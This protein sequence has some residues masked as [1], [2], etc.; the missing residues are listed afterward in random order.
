MLNLTPQRSDFYKVSYE[1]KDDVLKVVIND[2]EE[3]F[4]FTEMPNG[5]AK[6]DV[7][8]LS[9]NPFVEVKRENG[10]LNITVIR[11]Y[12]LEEKGEFENGY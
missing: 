11:F 6:V 9:V 1:L 8:K 12:S 7:E 3:V 4:D 2:V 5:V 10:K